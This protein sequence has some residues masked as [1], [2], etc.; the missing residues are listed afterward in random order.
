MFHIHI[1]ASI[2]T[3]VVSQQMHNDI[4]VHLLVYFFKCKEM[5]GSRTITQEIFY[6]QVTFMVR[7]NLVDGYQL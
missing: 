6:A 4:N 3:C 5:K 2:Y 7:S 1:L